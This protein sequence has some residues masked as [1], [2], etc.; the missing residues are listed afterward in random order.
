MLVIR[1]GEDPASIDRGWR[2]I[3]PEIRSDTRLVKKLRVNPVLLRY[4]M[5]WHLRHPEL[6]QARN[7]LNASSQRTTERWAG[8]CRKVA[9]DCFYPAE[10]A[11][12]AVLRDIG[13]LR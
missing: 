4:L 8:V 6:R 12:E 11:A 7:P 1:Y 5:L 9:E 2:V 3:V 13:E 10:D